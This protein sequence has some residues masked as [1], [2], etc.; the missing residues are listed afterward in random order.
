VKIL[1]SG[2]LKFDDRKLMDRAMDALHRRKRIA[3]LCTGARQEAQEMAYYWAVRN[4]IP[5]IV[6]LPMQPDLTGKLD[7]SRWNHNVLKQLML[8]GLDGLVAFP[9]RAETDHL[10]D[11][12][13]EHRIRVWRVPKNWQEGK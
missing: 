4:R 6:T 11:L 12:A 9:G 13:E 8:E 10:A 7:W 5:Y 3:C 2:G 1:V